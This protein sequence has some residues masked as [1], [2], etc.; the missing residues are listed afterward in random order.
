MIN[1]V[2]YFFTEHIIDQFSA[3]EDRLN[4]VAEFLMP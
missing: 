2:V 1:I 3:D 4:I